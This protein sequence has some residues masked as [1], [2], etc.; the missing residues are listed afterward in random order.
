MVAKLGIVVECVVVLVT[1]VTRLLFTRGGA[2]Y[3]AH[4]R[5][6]SCFQDLL[7]GKLNSFLHL[8]NLRSVVQYH[9]PGSCWLVLVMDTRDLVLPASACLLQLGLPMNIMIAVR[10]VLFSMVLSMKPPALVCP[11]SAVSVIHPFLALCV[12]QDEGQPS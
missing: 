7:P 10:M 4:L 9:V 3:L 8:I 6:I 11:D 12:K 5:A 1:L 2:V